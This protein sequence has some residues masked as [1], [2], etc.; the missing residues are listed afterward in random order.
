MLGV[1]RVIRERNLIH[2]EFSVIVR[3]LWQGMGIGAEL[4]KRCILIAREQGI[5]KINGTVL[6]ENTQMLRLG[7]KLGFKIKKIW[8]T[9]EFELSLSF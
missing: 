8:K 9:P 1:A 6:A 2:A 7:R 3:D 5:K 4:L